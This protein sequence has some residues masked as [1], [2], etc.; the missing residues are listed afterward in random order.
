MKTKTL[1]IA[2][3]KKSIIFSS[4]TPSTREFLEIL[5]VFPSVLAADNKNLETLIRE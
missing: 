2:K 1:R 4:A 5:K 3:G